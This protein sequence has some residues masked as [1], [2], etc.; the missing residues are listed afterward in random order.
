MPVNLIFEVK[1]K[2]SN[3]FFNYKCNIKEYKYTKN[4]N[5]VM[6]LLKQKSLKYVGKFDLIIVQ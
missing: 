3:T 6:Q 1:E 2:Y 4:T 5:F